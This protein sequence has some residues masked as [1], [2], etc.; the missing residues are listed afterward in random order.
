V[1][2]LALIVNSALIFS[3]CSTYKYNIANSYLDST[4]TIQLAE[5]PFPM[6]EM[7][8]QPGEM[9]KVI[10]AG[11]SSSVSAKLNQY[12]GSVLETDLAGSRGLENK[13]QQIDKD[14]Y[15]EYP[16]IGKVKAAGLTKDELQQYLRNAVEPYLKNPMVLVEIPSRGVTFLGEVKAPSTVS[17]P[18]ERPNIFE[19]LAQ[20]GYLTEFAD[21]SKVKVYRESADGKREF[22]HLDLNDTLFVNSPYFYPIP[23]DVVYIPASKDRIKR[24]N[25][26]TIVPYAGFVIS[27]LTLIIALIR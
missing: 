20:V 25:A 23:N 9:V 13:G 10:F 24:V 8:F 3:S 12:G 6:A 4:N 5:Y 22:G 15:I 11:E 21:I 2:I 14:G 18:K 1:W 17:F 27:L 26:T 16:Y 7:R 19:M